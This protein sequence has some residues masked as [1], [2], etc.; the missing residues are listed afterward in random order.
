MPT[1]AAARAANA[2]FRPAYRPVAV[3]VGGTGGIGAAIARVL[4]THLHGELDVV[5]VGRSEAGARAVL[6]ALPAPS[7]STSKAPPPL[8]EFVRCDAT[9]MRDIAR[10]SGDIRAKLGRVNY[11]VLTPGVLTLAGRDETDEGIDRKA[12]GALL[13]ALE[14]HQ[15][16][17]S[18]P[19]AACHELTSRAD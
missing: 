10:A 14:V 7:A 19:G 4:G 2:A 13:R 9:L 6:D 3:V 1:L 12:R 17:R 8:R 16:V 15:R 11:L 18:A 5:L